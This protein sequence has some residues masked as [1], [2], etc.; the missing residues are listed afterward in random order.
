VDRFICQNM[1]YTNYS[2][3]FMGRR[4]KDGGYQQAQV[5]GTTVRN[6]SLN[7]LVFLHNAVAEIWSSNRQGSKLFKELVKKRRKDCP[8]C[9]K[10]AYEEPAYLICHYLSSDDVMK[11]LD[12]N[13]RTALDYLQALREI[14][15][16]YKGGLEPRCPSPFLSWQSINLRE[17][18]IY[19]Q[20]F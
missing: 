2:D 7:K 6:N 1:T 3:R 9:V 11:V 13:R 12:C 20:L 5:V 4:R 10:Y 16:C 8:D 14:V 19:I 18:L 15:R 17:Q